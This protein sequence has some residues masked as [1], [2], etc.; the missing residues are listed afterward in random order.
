MRLPFAGG[1]HLE[2][3]LGLLWPELDAVSL[4]GGAHLEVLLGLLW[5]ELDAVS[6]RGGCSLG[7]VAGPVVAG[8]SC[9]IPSRGV[10]PCKCSWVCYGGN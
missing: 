3:L 6:L 7:S 9:G 4:G 10:F 8:I 5:P 2:V 1:A